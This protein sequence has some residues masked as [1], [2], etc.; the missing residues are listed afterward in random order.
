MLLFFLINTGKFLSVAERGRCFMKVFILIKLPLPLYLTTL[1][2]EPEHLKTA[3]SENGGRT[4]E[5]A[6]IL[7]VHL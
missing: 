4:G 6:P 1:I 3:I 5:N 7:H 2:L